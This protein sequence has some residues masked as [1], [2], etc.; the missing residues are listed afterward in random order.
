V[1]R[2][3]ETI[4]LMDGYTTTQTTWRQAMRHNGGTN[5]GFV[6]GHARWLHAGEIERVDTD[7]RGAYW[8]HHAAADR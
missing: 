7:G 2:P 8:S 3:A 6:D 5:A 4:S 1:R